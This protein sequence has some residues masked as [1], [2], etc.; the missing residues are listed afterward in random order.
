MLSSIKRPYNS[1]IAP[2]P[3]RRQQTAAD[4][5]ETTGITPQLQQVGQDTVLPSFA[6][7]TANLPD[8]P[9]DLTKG[10]YKAAWRYV[11]P[12]QLDAPSPSAQQSSQPPATSSTFHGRVPR[13][14]TPAGARLANIA[15]EQ[16]SG[17]RPP[18][19]VRPGSRLPVGSTTFNGRKLGDPDTGK[20]VSGDTPG[21]ITLSVFRNRQ[22]V[23]PTTGKKV[24]KDTEGAIPAQKFHH[25][26]LVDPKTGKTASKD[27]EG[28]IPAQKFRHRRLVDPK[29]GRPASKDTEGAIFASTFCDR[30][31][32]DPKTGKPAS[33]DTE[34]AISASTFYDRKLVDPN[35][36]KSASK[37]SEGA[38]SAVTF[39]DRKLVDPNT[40][41]PASKDTEGAISANAFRHRKRRL[42]NSLLTPISRPRS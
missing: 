24:S 42:K 36:G 14:P 18:R 35:T 34:G 5:E 1:E 40:G 16:I 11:A 22:L 30:K 31:L 25:R 23:D 10:F 15:K 8:L 2:Q 38:I 39:R 21:A 3:K 27:T 7:L 37:D 9:D 20:V 4:R 29:T 13:V 26:K 33:E 19:I 6:E 28:A 41:K 17:R 32:V 12:L